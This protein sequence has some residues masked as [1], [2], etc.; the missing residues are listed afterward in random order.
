MATTYIEIDRSTNGTDW[1]RIANLPYDPLTVSYNYYNYPNGGVT[2]Y[3]RLRTATR[4]IPQTEMP[5]ESAL[6]QSNSISCN[7]ETAGVA[8]YKATIYRS[9]DG[10]NWGI[11]ASN[12]PSPI[13]SYLYPNYPNHGILATFKVGVFPT[14]EV[15]Q[16]AQGIIPPQ[17][18]QSGSVVCDY[19]VDF[20]VET[21]L[22]RRRHDIGTWE[23]LADIGAGDTQHFDEELNRYDYSYRLK[24]Y[25]DSDFLAYSNIA[26]IFPFS[27][28]RIVKNGQI[29]YEFSYTK[30]KEKLIWTAL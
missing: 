6:V 20:Y 23:K 24:S 18:A 14:F 15:P 30:N 29:R 26:I 16:T 7:Y 3:F 13:I 1:Y 12:R 2:T 19:A 5:M 8:D 22:E 4:E 28:S 25:N 27:Y 11:I 17:Y 10:V 21:I 9:T